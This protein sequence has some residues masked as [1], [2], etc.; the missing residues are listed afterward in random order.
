MAVE[1]NQ[2]TLAVAVRDSAVVVACFTYID[3][4]QDRRERSTMC[5]LTAP[6]VRHSATME[7][8]A[9]KLFLSSGTMT[10]IVV[11]INVFLII[12]L[13]TTATVANYVSSSI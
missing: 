9:I 13:P 5:F 1:P 6:C 12:I 7:A 10:A 4:A 3:V 2:W 11:M 8:L